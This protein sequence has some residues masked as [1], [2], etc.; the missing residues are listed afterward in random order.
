VDRA[1]LAPDASWLAF[2]TGGDEVELWRRDL[3]PPRALRLATAAGTLAVSSDG[4]RIAA[5]CRG[6]SVRLLERASGRVLHEW[7]SAQEAA[8]GVALGAD[9]RFVCVGDLDGVRVW[10]ADTGALVRELDVPA[11]RVHDVALSTAG[12]AASEGWITAVANDGRQWTWSATTGELLHASPR[13]QGFL[14]LTR[15][16]R[17]ARRFAWVGDAG[18]LRVWDARTGERLAA[19]RERTLGRVEDLDLV[20]SRMVVLANEH[21][22]ATF[23]LERGATLARVRLPQRTFRAVALHPGTDCFA[24]GALDGSLVVWDTRSATPLVELVERGPAVTD[25]AFSPDGA[26]LFVSTEDGL[27]RG[28]EA[29]P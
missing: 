7:A 24:T 16:D 9:G 12:P 27:L 3:P 23:D 2:S 10:D 18:T 4:A 20:G 26:W 14:F 25:V 6:G 1:A 28:F 21:E 11:D 29:R 13:P 5:G 22:L 17:T 19:L 8:P 15:A